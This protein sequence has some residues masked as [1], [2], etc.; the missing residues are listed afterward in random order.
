MEIKPFKA[1]RFNGKVVGDTGSCI[2]PPYDVINSEQVD[3]LY[4]KNQYNVVRISKGKT[5]PSDNEGNNQY[6]RAAGFLSDWIKKSVL[7]Q[8][9]A[10]SIY[11]YVQDFDVAGTHY[12][13][14][15]F[16]ALGKLEEFGKIVRPHETTL[17]KPKMDR[18]LLT[19]A[20]AAQIG[21]IFLLYKDE[22][23]VADKIIEKAMKGKALI[24]FVDELDVQHRLFG[25]TDKQDVAA[26]VK[27]MGGK[28]CVIADGHHRYETALNY[29]K[30]T[31][32]PAASHL[33]MAFANTEN[34][35]LVV[36]AT[37][38]L[39][40]NLKNFDAEK[41]IASLKGNFELTSYNFDSS[42]SKAAAKQKMLSQ[43]KNEYDK[44][45]IAFGIYTGHNGFYVA[46]LK[47]KG[48]MG[49]LAPDKSPAWRS[50][51]LAVL[52]KLILDTVLGLD[53][54]KVTAGGNVEYVKDTPSAID[55]SIAKAD[56][57]KVQ[58]AILT[59]PPKMDQIN[60]VADAGEKMPQKST[61]FYPKV[62]T[63][64]TINKL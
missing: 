27:M 16:I 25:I 21:L 15:T 22:K 41:F 35:G 19:R 58:V 14:S 62:Y 20:T 3:A 8:D 31:G 51:D 6:T 44:D 26:I 53:E 47:D 40:N 61:F 56:A 24:D 39:V 45:K 12:T 29:Y 63:G 11:G 10:E 57:G 17:S 37:H 38:R 13:R 49:K 23:K 30:E 1:F 9:D 60:A 50:L 55:D 52:H 2:A 34:E 33:M 32:N 48:V 54:A 5:T 4:K 64:L 46:V 28:S 42:N 18:L 43:M 59:N 36:L 7:K